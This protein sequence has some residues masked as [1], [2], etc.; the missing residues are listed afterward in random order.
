[1]DVLIEAAKQA[2]ALTV[3]VVVVVYFLR[4]LE[5]MNTTAIERQKEIAKTYSESLKVHSAAVEHLA[6]EI[7]SSQRVM[8]RLTQ[9]IMFHDAT[10]KGV[11]PDT[12]GDPKDAIDKILNV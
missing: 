4:Y 12:L 9:V 11:N 1:M 10:V 8:A 3:L 2:P 7:K 5:R 6:A